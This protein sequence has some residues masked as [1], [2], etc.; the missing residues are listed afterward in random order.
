MDKN[1]DKIIE[2]D[3]LRDWIDK[4]R[5]SYMWDTIDTAIRQTDED[6]D[7]FI[8]WLEYKHSHYGKWDDDTD[9]D[10][11]SLRKGMV[12]HFSQAST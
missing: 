2:F 4:Q 9:I 6:K 3:E 10:P 11:V 1:N 8:S 12:R 5:I 7:D